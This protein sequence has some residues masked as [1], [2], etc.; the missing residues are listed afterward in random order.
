MNDMNIHSKSVSE[1]DV[2]CLKVLW[3]S[4]PIQVV[5]SHVTAHL[6]RS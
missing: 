5:Q 6:S 1:K 4:F 2:F 3:C